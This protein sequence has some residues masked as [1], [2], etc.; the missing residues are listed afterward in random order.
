MY[1]ASILTHH[2]FMKA[3]QGFKTLRL[4]SVS[5]TVF[6]NDVRMPRLV[7]ILPPSTEALVI[8]GDV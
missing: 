3:L 2:H 5:W 6:R 4:I 8:Y 1:Y 7:D